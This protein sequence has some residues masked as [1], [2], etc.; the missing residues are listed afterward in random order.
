MKAIRRRITYEE[1]SDVITRS[2]SLLPQ[3]IEQR[4]RGAGRQPKTTAPPF[5]KLLERES[6]VLSACTTSTGHRAHRLH[7][8]KSHAPVGDHRVRALGSVVNLRAIW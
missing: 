3:L 2:G 4:L 1:A 7:H 8:G 5:R 6:A